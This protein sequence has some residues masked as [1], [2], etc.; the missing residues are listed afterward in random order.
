MFFSPKKKTGKNRLYY[1]LS[2]L[3]FDELLFDLLLERVWGGE[4]AKT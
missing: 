4:I 3:Y 2:S 1:L